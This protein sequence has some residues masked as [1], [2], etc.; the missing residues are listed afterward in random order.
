M[1]MFR[2]GGASPLSRARVTSSPCALSRRLPRSSPS[3]RQTS[4]R[5]APAGARPGWP[6][7]CRHCATASKKHVP[8]SSC[9]WRPAIRASRCAPPTPL[10]VGAMTVST[11]APKPTTPTRSQSRTWSLRMRRTQVTQVPKR[12][13]LVP[14]SCESIERLQSR[15]K[16][17]TFGGSAETAS[18]PKRP[19]R[20]PCSGLRSMSRAECGEHWT[21][22]GVPRTESWPC[23]SAPLGGTAGLPRSF[24]DVGTRAGSRPGMRAKASSTSLTLIHRRRWQ[25]STM[26]SR[27]SGCRSSSGR[28]PKISSQSSLTRTPQL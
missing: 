3:V 18:K 28:R 27:A 5:C 1:I 14:V 20:G 12:V 11:C 17:T 15:Q 8:P 2:F 16:T 25:M 7:C 21:R 10:A 4:Q 23:R 24:A 26:R 13:R 6:S 19:S 22:H 9:A